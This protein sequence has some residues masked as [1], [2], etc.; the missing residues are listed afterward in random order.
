MHVERHLEVIENTGK[1]CRDS[2]V[3]LLKA[4]ETKNMVNAHD[5]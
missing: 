2:N 3:D 5:V 4:A 1:L